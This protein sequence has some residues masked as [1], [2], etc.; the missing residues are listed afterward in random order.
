MHHPQPS[1]PA[2]DRHCAF[3]FQCPNCKKPHLMNI[4]TIRPAMFRGD[5][6]IVYQCSNCGT[7]KT[8]IMA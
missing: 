7:E 6:L 1:E 8:V 4:K 5:D 3:L 2:H